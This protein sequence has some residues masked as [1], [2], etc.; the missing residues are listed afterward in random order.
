M[1]KPIAKNRSNITRRVTMLTLLSFVFVLMP[2]QLVRAEDTV[3]HS[4]LG[5]GKANR[6]VIVGEDG[7]IEWKYD[8][9]ASDGWVLP[10]GNVLLALYKTEGFPNG[11]VVEID[12]GECRDV[13]RH[14]HGHERRQF[15]LCLALV[16]A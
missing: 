13:L 12:Q 15:G 2:L 11:G 3:R 10:N 8:K 6:V 9:P 14:G 5:V 4:F 16:V 7:K 1:N